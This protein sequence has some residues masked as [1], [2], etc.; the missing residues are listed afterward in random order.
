MVIVYK[1]FDLG[2]LQWFSSGYTS[3]SAAEDGVTIS[4][5]RST[6]GCW[7]SIDMREMKP[8]KLT[9]TPNPRDVQIT[10]G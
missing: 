6:D 2:D 10:D 4:L 5:Q 8:Y 1:W 7:F 3:L 9:L